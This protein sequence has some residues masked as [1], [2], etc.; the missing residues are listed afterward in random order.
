MFKLLF[1]LFLVFNATEEYHFLDFIYSEELRSIEYRESRGD[2]T[3]ISSANCLGSWQIHPTYYRELGIEPNL[4]IKGGRFLY[5]KYLQVKVRDYYI[6]KHIRLLRELNIPVTNKSLFD[7]WE[8]IGF[9]IN[10]KNLY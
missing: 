10:R 1:P 7:C 2:S 9:V 6:V 4:Y 8:G 5:P 3:V